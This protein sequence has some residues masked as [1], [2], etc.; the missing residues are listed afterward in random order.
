MQE[1]ICCSC[2]ALFDAAHAQGQK[3]ALSLLPVLACEDCDAEARRTCEHSPCIVDGAELLA[4]CTC[5]P[6]HLLED[7]SLSADIVNAAYL[8]GMSVTRLAHETGGEAAVQLFCAEIFPAMRS[9]KPAKKAAVGI[10][11]FSAGDA[12]AICYKDGS[13]SYRV[14]DT[15]RENLVAHAD[16][17]ASKYF[18][19][20]EDLPADEQSDR[21]AAQWALVEKMALKLK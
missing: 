1:I 6:N 9:G 12:R 3:L 2:K 20:I 11:T 21:R 19:H 15:A 13:K 4:V 10:A 18:G 8:H 17:I 16:V 14:Y 5:H 7:G